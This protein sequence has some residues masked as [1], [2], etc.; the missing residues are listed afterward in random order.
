PDQSILS[1]PN[2]PF[3][4][5]PPTDHGKWDIEASAGPVASFYSWATLDAVNGYGEAQFYTAD[6]LHKI[7][8]TGQAAKEDLPAVRDLSIRACGWAP[9]TKADIRTSWRSTT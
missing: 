6:S 7:F 3:A 8:Q 1:D 2:N 9:S 5:D 4:T